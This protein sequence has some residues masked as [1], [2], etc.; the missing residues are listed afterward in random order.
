MFD[1]DKNKREPHPVHGQQV[2]VKEPA[3]EAAKVYNHYYKPCPYSHIDVYRVIDLF[4]ITHPALQ[5]ALKKI[6]VAGGRGAKNI[7]KDVEEAI[8]SLNRFLEMKNEEVNRE[9]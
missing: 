4:E 3:P 7:N 9:S 2:G 5:H 1:K 6:M 8:V